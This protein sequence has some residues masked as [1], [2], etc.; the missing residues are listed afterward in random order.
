MFQVHKYLT[1]DKYPLSPYVPSGL[2]ARE[3]TLARGGM[4]K[5]LQIVLLIVALFFSSSILLVD[6][7]Y[8]IL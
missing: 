8:Y 7:K 3:R 1:G 2:R 5:Y 6:D 4:V